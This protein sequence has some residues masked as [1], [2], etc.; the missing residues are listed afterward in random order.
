[1]PTE[2]KTIQ[3]TGWTVP[4]YFVV[5]R[6]DH[7]EFYF[8]DAEKLEEKLNKEHKGHIMNKW[9]RLNN[10]TYQKTLDLGVLYVCNDYR[11]DGTNMTFTSNEGE[12]SLI[13]HK[14]THNMTSMQLRAT[15][16]YNTKIA[17][18]ND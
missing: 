6:D 16:F 9:V 11:T 4:S 8:R 15:K 17:K 12:V 1:M 3:V 14:H 13:P 2:W 18:N 7:Q 5:V 10:Y